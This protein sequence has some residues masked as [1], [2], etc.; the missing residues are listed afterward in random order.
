MVTPNKQD[1]NSA[2]GEWK[3]VV[4]NKRER[5]PSTSSILLNGRTEMTRSTCFSRLGMVREGWRRRA[6]GVYPV[7]LGEGGP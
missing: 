7:W 3:R 5:D 1:G 4:N 2:S 6:E